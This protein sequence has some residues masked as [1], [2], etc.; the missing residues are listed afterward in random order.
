M[1]IVINNDIGRM[2]R[3]YNIIEY[4]SPHDTEGIDEYLKTHAYASL[5]KLNEGSSALHR[6]DDI[7][8][9][10]IREGK[11]VKLFKWFESCGYTVREEYKGVY[12]IADAGFFKTQVIVAKR[13]DEKAHIWI[14]SLT[15]HMN[16]EQARTLLNE[17]KNLLGRP[18]ADYVESVLQIASKANRRLF[19]ELKREDKNMYSALVELM[20]PEID[21]AISKAVKKTRSETWDEASA[22]KSVEAINNAMIKLGMSKEKACAFMDTTPEQYDKYQLLIQNFNSRGQK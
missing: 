8:F 21:E 9:T 3:W 7:T 4:K 16:R 13:L 12:Y 20:Q 6:L 18:E 15:D 19:N 1:D 11:P 2:F 17:S 5:Y 22:Q 14:T 10:M